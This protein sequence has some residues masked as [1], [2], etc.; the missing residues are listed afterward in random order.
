MERDF[1]ECQ[2]ERIKALEDSVAYFSGRNKWEREKWVVRQLLSS[3]NEQYGEC[4]LTECG[5]PVDVAFRDA[6]FQV[7]E[8]MQFCG[9]D[10]RYRHREYQLKLQCVKAAKTLEDLSSLTPYREVEWSQIVAE[11]VEVTN[12]KIYNYP[13]E[14]RRRLDVLC[15]YNRHDHFERPAPTP[16]FE[17]MECRSFS[18][19]SNSYAMVLLA[20]PT[21]PAFL[22]TAIRCLL[23]RPLS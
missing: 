7:K 2:T 23:R 4:E 11:S 10:I 20:N 8:A 6:R 5:E 22:R 15:Y 12:A 19:V 9:E 3:L 17:V 21:A 1:S 13:V 14:E 16:A 18:I